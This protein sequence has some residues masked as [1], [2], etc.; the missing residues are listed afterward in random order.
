MKQK[1]IV[2]TGMGTVNPLAHNVEDTWAAILACK[3][4]FSRINIFDAGTFPSTFA[5]QVSDYDLASQL[6]DA[7][8][9]CYAGR[10]CKFAL[11]AAVQAWRQSGLGEQSELDKSRVG[12]YLGSGEGS[13]D[14][15]NFT[16]LMV[17]AWAEAGAV[18]TVRWAKL[19]FERMNLNREIAQE[20]NMVVA[21]LAGE[22][23]VC[24]E[25]FNVLTACAASTQAIGEAA[26]QIRYGQSDAIITGGAHSMIHPYGV[27]GFNRLTALSTRN[28]E[29]ETASRPF[30]MTRDGFVLGE[31][32]SILILEDYDR[33]KARGA[34]ILAEIIGYG[35]SADA[36]RITDQDPEGDGAATSMR[37]AL[38]DA[39]IAP[40]QIDYISAHGTATKQN[41]QVE[42]RA[43]HAVF[44]DRAG[45]VPISSIKS[46]LGH[47]IAAA[48]ATELITCVLAI[49]DQVLPPTTNYREPDPDCDLDYVPN[50]PRKAKVETVMSNSF[51]FGGQ[52]DT[53]IIAR[54]E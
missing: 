22:F 18:D 13:L 19:A 11:G 39:G 23:G 28:N 29:I 49:R 41:D 37:N 51:G 25:A 14:F 24:G 33:A 31:G 54:G 30:D 4:A 43:V 34:K 40:E 10:H 2:I 53:L 6:S 42:T 9:H 44:G 38:A 20:S 36:F 12:I 21:H 17:D 7:E 15:E 5:A 8:P 1:R 27:T 52:N 48:G 45:R 50:E 35:S 3:S 47:L 46:M 26:M 32:A 16:S